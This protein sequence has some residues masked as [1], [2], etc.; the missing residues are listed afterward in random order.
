MLVFLSQFLLEL[1]EEKR[2]EM[3]RKEKEEAFWL[4]QMTEKEKLEY[5]QEKKEQEELE[6][7]RLEEEQRQREL[8]LEKALNEAKRI[9]AEEA[10]KKAQLQKRLTFFQSVREEATVLENS[11]AI[12]RAFVFSYY[13]LLRYLGVEAPKKIKVLENKNDNETNEL[14]YVKSQVKLS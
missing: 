5:L 4:Y 13:D 12:T 8:E 10:A 9:A 7:K 2:L 1:D 6:K 14:S 3:E 11:H